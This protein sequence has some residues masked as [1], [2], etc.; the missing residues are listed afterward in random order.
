MPYS[1]NNKEAAVILKYFSKF[2]VHFS[3]YTHLQ[4][5]LQMHM[6]IIKCIFIMIIRLRIYITG[7]GKSSIIIYTVVPDKYVNEQELIKRK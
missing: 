6:K 7:Q 5:D 3:L 4:L 2:Q 1:Q